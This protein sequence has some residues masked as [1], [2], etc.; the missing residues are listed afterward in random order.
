MTALSGNKG[1]YFVLLLLLSLATCLPHK[2]KGD[3]LLGKQYKNFWKSIEMF[4]ALLNQLLLQINLFETI[5][6]IGINF[7]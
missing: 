5:I 7:V 6:K 2:K 3:V 1:D 4:V